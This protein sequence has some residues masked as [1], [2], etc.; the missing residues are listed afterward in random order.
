MKALGSGLALGVGL[1]LLAIGI[2]ARAGYHGHPCE[3]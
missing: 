2:G 1:S 3:T